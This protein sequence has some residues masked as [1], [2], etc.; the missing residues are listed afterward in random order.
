VKLQECRGGAYGA[1]ATLA[2]LPHDRLDSFKLEVAKV[3]LETTDMPKL[4]Q[5]S[6]SN[7]VRWRNSSVWCG[8]YGE[9]LELLTKGSD[10]EVLDAMVGDL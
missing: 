5:H 3:I 6:I 9:W 7:V 2:L 10:P 4:R 8:A 1:P